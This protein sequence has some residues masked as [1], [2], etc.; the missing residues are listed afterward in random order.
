MVFGYNPKAYGQTA[1]WWQTLETITGLVCSG[2]VATAT[3][4][5]ANGYA[6]GDSIYVTGV[7]PSGYD[8]L[9][10]ITSV[11]TDTF[12]YTAPS[13]TASSGSGSAARAQRVVNVHYGLGITDPDSSLATDSVPNWGM[14]DPTGHTYTYSYVGQGGTRSPFNST[15]LRI[16]QT[17]S[18]TALTTSRFKFRFMRRQILN[19]ACEF[20]GYDADRRSGLRVERA[21]ARN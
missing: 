1:V 17:R 6:V 3:T 21:S 11:T 20:G 5:S 8:G 10:T 13:G 2:T 12:S 14:P 18:T 19:Y 15:R 9:V 4:Q 7:E 16:R